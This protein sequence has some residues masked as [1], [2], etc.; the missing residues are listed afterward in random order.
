MAVSKKHTY[1][2]QSCVFLSPAIVPNFFS[3][4]DDDSR[5]KQVRKRFRTRGWENCS[6]Y[7]PRRYRRTLKACT[8]INL[9]TKGPR[10]NV[11]VENEWAD[12]RA[13]PIIYRTRV[14]N[15][16]YYSVAV[17]TVGRKFPRKLQRRAAQLLRRKVAYYSAV[18]LITPSLFRLRSR[19]APCPP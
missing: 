9:R 19:S 14:N 15:R 6:P 3:S 13:A 18:R 10:A 2:M 12:T 17:G 5:G 1:T 11:V 7:K 4:T 16:A 8:A